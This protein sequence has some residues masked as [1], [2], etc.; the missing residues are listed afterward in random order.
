MAV[1][2]TRKGAGWLE[3]E[4]LPPLAKIQR[5]LGPSVSGRILSSKIQPVL[6]PAK[7]CQDPH[8][9][10]ALAAA[11]CVGCWPRCW[12]QWRTRKSI[13][14]LGLPKEKGIPKIMVVWGK[15]LAVSYLA[16]VYRLRAEFWRAERGWVHI[17]AAARL[18]L[19]REGIRSQAAV[20]SHL[21]P[22]CCPQVLT[23]IKAWHFNAWW[24]LVFEPCW[25]MSCLLAG[26]RALNPAAP[27]WEVVVRLLPWPRWARPPHRC[28]FHPW[29]RM[30]WAFLRHHRSPGKRGYGQGLPRNHDTGAISAF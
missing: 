12:C 30:G 9:P 15:C 6:P 14:T 13:A 7:G 26:Q 29:R 24:D 8:R 28:C 17:P 5:L 11:P 4:S 3:I 22:G 23:I 10:P 1:L 19:Q 18:S 20:L 21:Q 16:T 27:R 25:I 2:A